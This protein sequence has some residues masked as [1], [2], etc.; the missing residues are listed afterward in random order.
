MSEL[1]PCC[2]CGESQ[3]YNLGEGSTYRWWKMSCKACDA[4]FGEVNADRTVNLNK[5]PMPE[6]WRWADEDWNAS[7]T[8]AQELRDRIAE[9]EKDAARYKYW[10]DNHGWTGTFDD[11]ATN[12]DEPKDIDAAIDTAMGC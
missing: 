3:G 12:S 11:G 9:L 2:Q 4:S 1:L 6:R 5:S 7:N 10:R 8:H